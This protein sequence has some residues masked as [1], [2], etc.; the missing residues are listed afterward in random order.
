MTNRSIKSLYYALFSVPMRINGHLYRS[1]RQRGQ[2]IKV[3]LGCGQKNYI[4]GWVNLDGNFMTAKIDLWAN[5]ENKLPFRDNSVEKF[6]SFHVIEHLTD[7]S[8]SGLFLEMRRALVPGGAIRVG[9]PNIDNACLK[10]LQND[11]RWFSDFPE[12][13][14]SI[15]GKFANFLFCRN[16]HLTALTKSY[17]QEI[18]LAAGFVDLQFCAPVKESAYFNAEVLGFEYEDD[19][20]CPHSLLLEA[21]K[22][23]TA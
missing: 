15:G 8:L 11:S 22:P 5:L 7:S 23:L 1:F 2:P 10:F 4:P 6:Y 14:A 21:R 19:H 13:R 3:H 17:L 18:A 20:E 12:A 9:G 16:E